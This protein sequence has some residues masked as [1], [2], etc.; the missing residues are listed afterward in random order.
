[1][2]SVMKDT[3][4]KHSVAISVEQLEVKPIPESQNVHRWKGKEEKDK[5]KIGDEKRSDTEKEGSD[6]ENNEKGSQKKKLVIKAPVAIK[7]ADAEDPQYQTLAGL[8]DEDLFGKENEYKPKKPR[9]KL[10][11]KAPIGFKKQ[12]PKIHSIR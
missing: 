5:K 1:M 11:I 12:M 2:S 3:Q 10:I 8:N 6:N 7:K 9:K 4:E